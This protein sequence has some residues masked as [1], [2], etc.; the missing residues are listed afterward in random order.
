MRDTDP[1]QLIAMYREMS[2]LNENR[3]LPLGS[4]FVSMV[5]AILDHEISKHPIPDE[6]L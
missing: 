1:S 5:E 4:T 3:P 6:P 2:A